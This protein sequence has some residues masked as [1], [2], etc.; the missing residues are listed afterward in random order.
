MSGA[1][2]AAAGPIDA[3]GL[4][5]DPAMQARY[6]GLIDDLRCLVCQ[7]QSIS[8]SNADLAKDLRREVRAMLRKGLSDDEIVKFMVDRYGDFVL[9]NP[10]VRGTTLLLWAGPFAM[11]FA[12]VLVAAIFV[13]RL[14]AKAV[15]GLSAAD[16]EKARRLMGESG[17]ET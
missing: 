16:H 5:D 2:M 13:R 3:D 11:L 15:P 10:P 1:G 8:D 12:G 14:R 6:R 4:N 9:Y 17:D 7:N